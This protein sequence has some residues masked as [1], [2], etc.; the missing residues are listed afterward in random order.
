MLGAW[1]R[2]SSWVFTPLNCVSCTPVWHL[3]L[4]YSDTAKD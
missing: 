2:R 4:T 1:Q 3:S